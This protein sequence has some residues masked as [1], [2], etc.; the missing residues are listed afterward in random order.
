M[1]TIH[2]VA[3]GEYVSKIAR[4]YGFASHHTIWD[5]PENKELK[6]KR[7]NPNILYPG[8]KLFIPDKELREESRA[9]EKKHR[10]EIQQEKLMLRIRVLALDGKPSANQECTLIVEGDSRNVVTETDGLIEMEISQTAVNGKLMDRASVV[11]HP[12]HLAEIKVKIGYLDPIDKVSGQ[13]ARLN[14]LGYKAGEPPNHL[15][16]EDEEE[17]AS[18]TREFLSAIEEFQCDFGLRVDGQI[19]PL[20]QAKLKEVHGC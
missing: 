13:L 14:H 15:L 17:S 16:S 11:T 8:D 1:G 6:E 2:V 5:A 9:T 18:R 20:T 3:Q 4:V 19:G 10:F 7:K 12:P